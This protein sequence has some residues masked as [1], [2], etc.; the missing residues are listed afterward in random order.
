MANGKE[1]TFLILKP[2]AKTNI[3]NLKTRGGNLHL[4]E[5]CWNKTL[6]CKGYKDASIEDMELCCTLKLCYAAINCSRSNQ[7]LNNQSDH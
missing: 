1:V 7:G 4:Y 3:L 2:K 6:G 5:L